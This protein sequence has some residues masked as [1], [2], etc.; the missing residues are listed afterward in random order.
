[1][2]RTS[3]LVLAG[4]LI[5]ALPLPA[6]ELT[7]VRV[8]LVLD[9]ASKD[10]Q[11][12]LIKDKENLHDLLKNNIPASRLVLTTL[13]GKQVNKKAILAHYRN[14]KPGK[15]EGLVFI[16]GGH[17]AMDRKRHFL[18]FGPRQE[19][20]YRSELRRAMLAKKAPLTVI[21][22]DCCSSPVPSTFATTKKGAV[23][24]EG[25]TRL[26]PVMRD[27]FFRTR[28]LVD[29]TGAQ[30][31][32]PSWSDTMTGGVFTQALCFTLVRPIKE[33][34]FNK[35]GKV[36][37]DEFF[38]AVQEHTGKSFGAWAN[39]MR[40]LNQTIDDSV[41][42]PDAFALPR[43]GY[44]VLSIG[45]TTTKDLKYTYRWPGQTRWETIVLKPGEKRVHLRPRGLGDKVLMET[46]IGGISKVQK[47]PAKVWV[48]NQAPKVDN[49][50]QFNIR[51]KKQAA[52]RSVAPEM[53]MGTE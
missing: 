52:K 29:I 21:L 24:S 23:E 38:V 33:L 28:G 5:A 6:A 1:M 51:S 45:N 12:S 22:T 37:W 25:E 39:A 42:L 15:N 4:W 16:Y 50:N 20:L 31:G 35:D 19:R 30:P 41:Q 26:H 53:E 34:D 49:G 3:L 44:A 10:L 47:L 32:K 27:L 43:S 48:G 9:T 8:L 11:A 18:A 2:V 14:L 46:R 7:K 17:G 40:R 13:T 36:T